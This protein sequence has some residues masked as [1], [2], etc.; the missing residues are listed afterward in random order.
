MCPQKKAEILI[1]AL[2]YIRKF[3]GSVVVI[4][5]GGAALAK[6]DLK[7]SF[8]EDVTLLKYIGINPVIVHGGGPQIGGTLDRMGISSKFYEGLRITDDETMD[9]AEMVLVGSINQA[10]VSMINHSGGRA[11]GLSGKDG[12][13]VQAKKARPYKAKGMAKEVVDLG[14]VGE[15]TQVNPGVIDTLDRDKYIPVIAP[16]GVG[17]NGEAYNINADI[18]AGKIAGAL[19]AEKL[20]LLTDTEGVKG[21]KKEYIPTLTRKKAKDLMKQGVIREGM[22][23]KVTCCLDALDQGVSK[24]HI[25]DGRVKHAV[26]LEIFTDEGVGTEIKKA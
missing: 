26:L 3:Y 16:I 5:Y 4:K 11:V 24:A 12:R 22:V 20:I 14:R 18:A 23:P 8:A 19:K 9:V 13:L 1:E 15:I 21:D 17:E 10:I 7:K 6:A 25:V 2:P